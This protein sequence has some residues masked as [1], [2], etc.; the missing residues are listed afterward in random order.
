MENPGNPAKL[1]DGLQV[2]YS[3]HQNGDLGMVYYRVYNTMVNPLL[4]DGGPLE[5]SELLGEDHDGDHDGDPLFAFF[6]C[7]IF[8]PAIVPSIFFVFPERK[9]ARFRSCLGSA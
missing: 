7:H 2:C 5:V 9:A 4:G 1:G 3:T 8:Y 6:F